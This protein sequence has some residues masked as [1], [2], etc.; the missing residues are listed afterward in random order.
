MGNPFR[1][2]PGNHFFWP[3]D[4]D[5]WPTNLTYTPNLAKV[6][7]N[8][9]TE[10]EG[11][12]SHGSAVRVFTHR[13]TDTHTDTQKDGSDSMT[14]AADAGGNK[15]DGLLTC[16]VTNIWGAWYV[17]PKFLIWNSP[18]QQLHPADPRPILV[19]YCVNVMNQLC[20]L[21][22]PVMHSSSSC[23]EELSEISRKWK[24]MVLLSISWFSS[25]LKFLIGNLFNLDWL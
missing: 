3:C 10:N 1:E 4:L 2:K 19:M 14:S 25:L 11:R 15:N 24:R 16:E 12:G 6:K 8:Y 21:N 5:L 18:P 13:H 9:H 23:L 20:L 22:H 17:N 7:V